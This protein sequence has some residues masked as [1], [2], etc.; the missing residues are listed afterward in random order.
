MLS[1]ILT[2]FFEGNHSQ[3]DFILLQQMTQ[4]KTVSNRT[5]WQKKDCVVIKAWK[6]AKWK[7]MEWL[8]FNRCLS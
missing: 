5:T 2:M 4:T 6:T 1:L 7:T 3:S 8:P